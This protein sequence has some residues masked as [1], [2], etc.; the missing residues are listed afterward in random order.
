MTTALTIFV[1][2]FIFGFW[3]ASVYTWYREEERKR[4]K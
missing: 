4:N 2:F 1:M 3:A